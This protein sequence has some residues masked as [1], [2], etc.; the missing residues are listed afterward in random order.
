MDR[1]FRTPELAAVRK[2][3]EAMEKKE[4]ELEDQLKA[5]ELQ[6]ALEPI[7][8]PPLPTPPLAQ[9]PAPAPPSPTKSTP[10]TPLQE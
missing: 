8:A 10:T 3:V 9:E 2:L 7:P 4:D 5:R 6:I 1:F